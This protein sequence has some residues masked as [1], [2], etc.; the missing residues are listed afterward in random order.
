MYSHSDDIVSNV[1]ICLG[2]G[3][4]ESVMV[5]ELIE[6]TERLLGGALGAMYRREISS[7]SMH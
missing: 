5:V 4:Q 1:S 7:I 2:S 3:S 6:M